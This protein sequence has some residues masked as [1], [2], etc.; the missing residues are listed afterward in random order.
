MSTAV[1]AT[2]DNFEA[3]VMMASMDLP[4]LVDFWAPWCGPCRTLM[5]T[6]ERIVE[7]YQGKLK[8]VKVNTDDEG[9][10]AQMFGIRS[11]PTVI[12]IK[13]GRP[14]DGF[15]GAQPEG[16]IRTFLQ[17]HLIAEAAPEEV[18][19]TLADE[20]VVD[21][22]LETR[23]VEAQTKLQESPDKEEL[24][25]DL[26]DLLAQAGEID[27]AKKLL[28]QLQA[29][30]EGDAAKRVRARVHFAEILESAASAVDLQDRIARN[31]KDLQARHHLAARFM[32]AGQA[33][34]AL[35]Q[36][37]TIVKTDRTF[38]SDLGRKSMLE[39]FRVIDDAELVSE[40][41]RKLSAAVL[42]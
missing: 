38:E 11:L 42:A 22:D 30:A 37:L 25:A 32:M 28:S 20:A 40:Y 36:W 33:A 16:A 14:V 6:L 39:A 8:L 15:M 10:L 1:V 9:T 18:E 13:G 23:I 17:K 26:A 4:V 24:K 21:Q 2:Q 3:E 5:P 19:A 12:L 35:D 31:S 27:A 29:L 34:S 41:R 7:S